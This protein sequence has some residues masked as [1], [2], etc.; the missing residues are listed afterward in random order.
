MEKVM[1]QMFGPYDI[2]GVDGVEITGKSLE[3]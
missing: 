1:Q 3:S 2:D